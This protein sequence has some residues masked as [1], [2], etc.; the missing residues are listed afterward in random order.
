MNGLALTV[1]GSYPAAMK[2]NPFSPNDIVQPGMFVGRGHEVEVI[3]K[4][5]FQAVHSNPHHFLI[6]GERGI[7][8][9]SLLYLADHLARG[10]LGPLAD[11]GLSFVVLSVDAGS[12]KD[13]LD[14]VK[15]IG[16][17]LKRAIA[18]LRENFE[19]AKRA[20]EFLSRWEILGVKYHGNE[21]AR[22]DPDEIRDELV[23]QI[24][25]L[26]DQG[27]KQATGIF[28]AIDEADIPPAHV[29]MGSFLKSFIEQLTKRGCTKVLLG[30]AGQSHVLGRLRE[31][32]ES[33]V[34]LF[35]VLSLKPLTS[36]EAREVVYKG[37]GRADAIN[38]KPTTITDDAMELLAN[39]SEGYPHFL[40]QFAASA[41]D[42]DIDDKIDVGD[43]LSG[44]YGDDGAINQ[45]GKKYFE[46]M[47]HGRVNSDD[48]RKVLNTMAQHG[49]SW[50]SR[51]DII[52]TSGVK[53]SQVNNALS[54]LKARD[55]IVADESRQ[56]FYRL[57]TRSFAAWINALHSVE[58]QTGEG[59]QTLED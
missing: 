53:E 45:L 21:G 59:L 5:L 6:E 47:Y 19:K 23:D 49:D 9:S 37:L 32:H 39:L 57:P 54:A 35:Q 26:L 27:D 48:Y 3:E 25:S 10:S 41:F 44:A 22:P 28:L 58:E 29:G 40:Q 2:F 52:R 55:V 13:E 4:S 36:E 42:A 20:W 17:E 31:S 14:L 50:V 46:E 12:I 1:L 7:G 33:S 56:G 43:V 8:K 11:R 30:L 24:V 51:R 15:A 18:P 16:R 34:R 38:E